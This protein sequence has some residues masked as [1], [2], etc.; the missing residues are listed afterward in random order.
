MNTL[1]NK[2][3]ELKIIARR[4]RPLVFSPAAAPV[5]VMVVGIL[6]HASFSVAAT[7]QQTILGGSINQSQSIEGGLAGSVLATNPIQADLE[8]MGGE[9]GPVGP[10]SDSVMAQGP[11]GAFE[12]PKKTSLKD[13]PAAQQEAAL[14]HCGLTSFLPQGFMWPAPGPIGEPH[15]HI[16]PFTGEPIGRDIPNKLGTT[17]VASGDGIVERAT[18]GWEGGYGNVIIIN[19]GNGLKTLYSHLNDILVTAGEHKKKGE[20][21]GF[22]GSTGHS[23]G[24]HVH[25]EVRCNY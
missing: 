4:V 5:A 12:V 22:M 11:F 25:F 7:N 8:E 24:P 16:D 6:L 1:K 13:T 18:Y 21:I 23:T 19:H 15:G 10:F 20:P 14:R 2:I 9:A 3:N 17:I